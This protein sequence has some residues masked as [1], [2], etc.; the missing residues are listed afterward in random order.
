MREINVYPGIKTSRMAVSDWEME[1]LVDE[2]S[3]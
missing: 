2:G 1:P 3:D